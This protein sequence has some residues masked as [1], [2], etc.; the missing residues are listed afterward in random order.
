MCL[1]GANLSRLK[2]VRATI[3]IS[4][5]SVQ[6]LGN[7]EEAEETD[8]AQEGVEAAGA[9]SGR[10]SEDF[11]LGVAQVFDRALRA[12]GLARLADQP[13]VPDQLVGNHD[14]SLLGDNLD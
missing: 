10:H 13:P 2:P 6:F 9:L 5:A 8:E 7:R 11:V 12:A 1:L 4:A 14:P 3:T